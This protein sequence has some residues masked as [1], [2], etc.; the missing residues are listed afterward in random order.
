MTAYSDLPP[1]SSVA[2]VAHL[3]DVSES[4]VRKLIA[5]GELKAVRLGRLIRV[6]RHALADLLMENGGTVAS[7]AVR[8]S[9]TTDH[10]Y[11]VGGRDAE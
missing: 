3:L 4:L 9:I 11:I 7:A 2:E 10:P 8:S 6:P 5:T 1:V